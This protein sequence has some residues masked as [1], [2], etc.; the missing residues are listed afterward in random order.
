MKAIKFSLIA[1]ALLATTGA[2]AAQPGQGGF[3]GRR[4]PAPEM[5]RDQALARADQAF[6]RLDTNNDG[7]VTADE[8]RQ[9]GQARMQ[10]RRARMEQRQGQRAERQGQMFDR[11]DANHDGQISR[12]EFAQRRALRG[13]RGPRGPRGQH[14]GMGGGR[15]GGGERAMAMFGA[16]GVITREEFRARALERF[17]RAD[18]NG[19][20][21]ITPDERR[22]M[23]MQGERREP[24]QN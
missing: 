17:Q 7:R 19:D 9:A 11:L 22:P 2:V 21:R 10:E 1:G 16:D 4:G 8:A 6:A 13:E 23:R 20:G 24:A 15:R 12:E 18:T 5:T 3:E 14:A